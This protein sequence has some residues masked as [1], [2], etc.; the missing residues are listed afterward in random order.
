MD[1]LNRD[2]RVDTRDAAL[3]VRAIERVEARHPDLVGGAGVYRANSAH[4]PFAHIDV[5]GYRAR[6]GKV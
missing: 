3:M 5:R 1:D 4:G 6:W 2:G